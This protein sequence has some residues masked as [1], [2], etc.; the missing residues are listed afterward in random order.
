MV[1]RVTALPIKLVHKALELSGV[2]AVNQLLGKPTTDRFR[3][4]IHDRVGDTTD[5][6]VLDVG[7]GI[8]NYRNSFGGEY[9]G[10]DINRA[11]I[12]T[13]RQRFS[14]RFEVMDAAALHAV[15]ESFDDVVTIATTH[16]LDDN[17]FVSMV[18][19]GLALLRHEG[20]LHVIDAILP[21]SSGKAFKTFWFGL[22]RGRYPRRLE[23]MKE[24]ASRAGRIA[25]E[26]IL[27]GPLHDTA[28]LR[29]VP[30]S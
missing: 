1:K 10:V 25:D 20:A 23:A 2:Y 27:D 30:A 9:V 12:E 15:G 29:I 26:H 5:R 7:C 6:R 22:D 14:G 4:L 18:R 28:Y 16:H 11:Y 3:R 24:L 13:A 19:G 17:Q 21:V 8:G